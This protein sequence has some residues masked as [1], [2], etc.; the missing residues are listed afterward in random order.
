MMNDGNSLVQF[1]LVGLALA[2]YLIDRHDITKLLN[3]LM[4][5]DYKEFQY[6]EHKYPNDVKAVEDIRKVENK[7]LEVVMENLKKSH[8]ADQEAELAA[9]DAWDSEEDELYGAKF[10]PGRKEKAGE[11]VPLEE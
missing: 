1:A 5:R 10:V 9:D 2:I 7:K 3:R 6:F 4:A 8:E 11:S